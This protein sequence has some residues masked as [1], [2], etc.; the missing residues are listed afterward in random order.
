V[1]IVG[2]GVLGQTPQREQQ[3]MLLWLDPIAAGC[4]HTAVQEFPDKM[5]ELS[6]PAKAKLR[7]ISCGSTRY[8]VIL[9]GNHEMTFQLQAYHRVAR[10][11]TLPGTSRA[12]HAHLRP[13][14]AQ[15][16]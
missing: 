1:E 16:L 4:F 12:A 7:N 5:T 9:A 14:R 6:K 2:P 13:F 8:V 3:L 11:S 10:P 15:A